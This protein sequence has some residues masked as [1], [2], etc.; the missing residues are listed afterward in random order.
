MERGHYVQLKPNVWKWQ[1]GLHAYS[2]KKYDRLS[3]A[4][5]IR[6]I[7]EQLTRVGADF[8]VPIEPYSDLLM[9]QQPWIESG[10]KVQFN[11]ME[12]RK[13]SLSVLHQLHKTRKKV[14]WQD[15]G[16]FQEINLN[17]KWAHRL[18]KWQ[19]YETFLYQT[20]GPSK[21]QKITE[22]AKD[23][24]A[25]LIPMS[26]EN[27]TLLH[28]DVVHHNFVREKTSN[29]LY[30]IDFDLAC[31]GP[32]EVELVLWAHRVLPHF[33]YD[34]KALL[35]EHPTLQRIDLNYLLFPNE[36]MREW[37]YASTLPDHQLRVFLP[38]LKI[39]TDK[40]LKMMPKLWSD[41]GWNN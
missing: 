19:H 36:L 6:F 38:K 20:L 11:N 2:L 3:D 27:L 26:R 14:K 34:V 12:D 15:S 10:R 7:H 29:R 31:I 28:G 8:M 13:D 25:K 4:D 33:D 9:I 21:T 24:L 22:L 1:V 39:F 16:H 41:Q 32:P 18:E 5:K 40:A 35:S 30:L 17:R 23:S 37:L